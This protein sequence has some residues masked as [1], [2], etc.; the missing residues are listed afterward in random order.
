MKRQPDVK[1]RWFKPFEGRRGLQVS[2]YEPGDILVG[3][4]IAIYNSD[5]LQYV[6]GTSS[7]RE[8]SLLTFRF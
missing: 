8:D 4:C 3:R 7:F 1:L 6:E 5:R 2:H